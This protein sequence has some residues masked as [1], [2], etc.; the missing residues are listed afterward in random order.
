M[1]SRGGTLVSSESA[2]NAAS[3]SIGCTGSMPSAAAIFSHTALG[4]HG[5]AHRR[6]MQVVEAVEPAFVAEALQR[7]VVEPPVAHP[8]RL[9]VAKVLVVARRHHGIGVDEGEAAVGKHLAEIVGDRVVERHDLLV[10]RL[11]V[12]GGQATELAETA[13]IFGKVAA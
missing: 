1:S 6:G 2:S 4:Q 5:I 7:H 8:D 3:K 12:A 13:E 9:A 10:D 11:H